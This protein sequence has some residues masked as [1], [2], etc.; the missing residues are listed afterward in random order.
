MDGQS[1]DEKT[2]NGTAMQVRVGPGHPPVHSR[3]KPGNPGGPGRPR[4]TK[5]EIA[6]RDEL[7]TL[8]QRL[9]D[10]GPSAVTRIIELSEDEDDKSV[11]LNASK[12]LTDKALDLRANRASAATRVTVTMERIEEAERVLDAGEETDDGQKD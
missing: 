5:E 1:G 9:L 10:A 6:R 3:F 11:A 7:K 4:L 12:Y 2:E 8:E